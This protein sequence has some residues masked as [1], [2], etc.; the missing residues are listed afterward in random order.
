[1]FLRCFFAGLLLLADAMAAFQP[2]TPEDRQR[3]V[4]NLDELPAEIRPLFTPDGDFRPVPTPG[5]TDWLFQHNETGQTF[6]QYRASKANH[7]S[8]PRNVIYLLPLGE[9]PEETTPDLELVRNYTAAFYQMEVR[10]L[11]GYLPHDLEF[12]PRKNSRSAQR[13]VLAP[14]VMAYLK[15]RLPEDAY[16]LLG[17]TM[18]DLYP[19]PTWNFV[20]GQASLV[21]RVGIFS[22]ARYDPA[23]WGDERGKDYRDVILQRTCKVLVH[24]AAHMFGLPHCIHF[25]CVVNGSNSMAETDAQPQHLCVVCLRKI[26]LATGFD[27]VRR[28]RDLA[29]F[30]RERKWWDEL[31]FVNRQLARLPA[32]ASQ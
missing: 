6:N 26:Y 29:A 14:D 7:P 16:C 9:F 32:P 3:A 27:P 23:F 31:D 11:P 18:E 10:L 21:E 20:F 15:T 30:Y 25:E 8:A 19:K 13:Q 24:E 1:M 2:P 22:L 12:T 5:T 28:Y 17:V 4:G